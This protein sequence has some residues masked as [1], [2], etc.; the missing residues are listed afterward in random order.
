M[1]YSLLSALS[2]ALNCYSLLDFAVRLYLIDKTIGDSMKLSLN[3]FITLGE[4]L[5]YLLIE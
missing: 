4:I 3:P 2:D 5:N 1:N